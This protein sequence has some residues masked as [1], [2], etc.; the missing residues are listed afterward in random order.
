MW[1]KIVFIG[2]NSNAVSLLQ[3]YWLKI[4]SIYSEMSLLEKYWLSNGKKITKNC[5]YYRNIGLMLKIFVI[6]FLYY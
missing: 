6:R 4:G 1:P 3:K 5:H 2:N